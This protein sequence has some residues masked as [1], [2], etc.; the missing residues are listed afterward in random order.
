LDDLTFGPD[1]GD[2][3]V[4]GFK[5]GFKAGEAVCCGLHS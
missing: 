1:G 5:L 4:D 3:L 2:L